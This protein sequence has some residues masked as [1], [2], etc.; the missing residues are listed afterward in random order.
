MK[1]AAISAS[2]N[3]RHVLGSAGLLERFDVVVDGE[4]A[5]A[6]GLAGKPDL[7]ARAAA[8]IG[9]DPARAVLLEDATSG[10]QAGREAGCGLVVGVDREDDG[11][12]HATNLRDAGAHTVVRNVAALRFPRRLPTVVERR[13]E[14]ARLRDG[15]PLALFLDFDGTLSPIV[16]DPAA[17]GISDA[18]RTAVRELARQ[19][20][21]AIVSGRDRT[22]VQE[23]AR[24]DGIF[25]A[26]SHGLDIAGPERELTQPA[27]AEAVPQVDAAERKL[28]EKLDGIAG[29]VVERKRFSV[30]AHYR[31]VAAAEADRVRHAAEDVLAAS[32]LLHARAGKKVVELVP[33]IDWDK[34][35]A[36]AWLLDALEVDPDD[37]LVVYIG[38]DETDEDAFR[39]L[40]GRGLGIHVGDAVSDTLGDYR[41]ADPAAVQEFLRSLVAT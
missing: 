11:G 31:M 26:G 36:V 34:G 39:A 15:R 4:V 10:V 19:A 20:R 14:F 9:V 2:R 30:A 16:D 25:Y 3:C 17:A 21:V 32:D 18:M 8:S 1:L 41:L 35:R 27:A 22:D 37:T 24:V 7:I 28:R 5:A 40:A 12:T 29:A 38:D 23:R 6:E 13:G 33:A